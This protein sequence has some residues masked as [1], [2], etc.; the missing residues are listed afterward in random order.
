[1]SAVSI[2]GLLAAWVA[3]G[4]AAL[5]GERHYNLAEFRISGA[6]IVPSMGKACRD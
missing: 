3:S 6:E 1:M 2:A 5:A 4:I